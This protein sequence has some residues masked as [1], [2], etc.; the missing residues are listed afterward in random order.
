ME[1]APGRVGKAGAWTGGEEGVLCEHLE[2]SNPF[3]AP[4]ELM[5]QINA[6]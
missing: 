3:Y 5:D 6:Q 1:A 4:D 2:V